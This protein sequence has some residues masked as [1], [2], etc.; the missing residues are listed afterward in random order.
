M[1]KLRNCCI[2]LDRILLARARQR[3]KEA[4][5]P[6]RFILEQALLSHFSSL[7]EGAGEIKH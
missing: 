2:S 5:A 7:E 6:M 4:G 1:T 3:A